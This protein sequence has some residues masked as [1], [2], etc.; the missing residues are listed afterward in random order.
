MKAEGTTNGLKRTSNAR[1]AVGEAGQEE[2][3]RWGVGVTL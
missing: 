2:K 1:A 3:T